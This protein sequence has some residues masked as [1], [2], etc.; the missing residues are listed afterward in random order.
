MKDAKSQHAET[1]VRLHSSLETFN[2]SSLGN[3]IYNKQSCR[4]AKPGDGELPRSPHR[5][6]RQEDYGAWSGAGEPGDTG[7]LG[8]PRELA[9]DGAQATRG[10]D[11]FQ[12]NQAGNPGGKAGSREGGETPRRQAE[13]RDNETMKLH[14]RPQRAASG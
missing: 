8:S 4:F 1:R 12:E 7:R 5:G 6:S 11:E 2:Y 13:C 9:G 14:R 3:N 10:A